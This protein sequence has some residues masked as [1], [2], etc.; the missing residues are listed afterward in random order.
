MRPLHPLLALI[1]RAP[2]CGYELK[3]QVDA[4]FAP[5]WQI[6]FAQLYRSLAQLARVG[7]VRMQS[8]PGEG[9]PP[10]KVYAL[11]PKGRAVLVRWLAEASS[12][13]TEAWVKRR[14]ARTLGLEERL[15]LLISASDD[16]LLGGLVEYANAAEYVVGSVNG[17]LALAQEQ[18]DL[19]GAHLLDVESGEYNIPF[20]Q[21]LIPEEDLLLVNL[22]VR[23]HGLMVAPGNPHRIRS[24]RD[25]ARR[26][27]RLINRGRGTGTRVWLF[28]QLRAAGIDPRTIN[29]WDNTVPTYDRVAKTIAG[30]RADVGPGLRAVA[31]AH[32][33]DFIPLGEERY[34][35]VVPRALYEAQRLAALLG[36]LED[37]RLHKWAA[38]LP[39][40]DLS[41]TG[42]VIAHIQYAHL[43]KTR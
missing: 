37:P 26:Q 22:A 16:P 23:E 2:A 30:G 27:V 17:L 10:R 8:K 5:R 34:D 39:G 4:E 9:G 12:D 20:V 15:P 38:A 40:Y 1:A 32:G 6:D 19:A 31:S 3:R 21:H 29:G 7:W 43:R 24:A 28:A 42:R 25:L 11:T 14:L 13:P 18:S 36:G 41:R 33:L 35:L